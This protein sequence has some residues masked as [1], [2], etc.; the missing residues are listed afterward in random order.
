MLTAEQMAKMSPDQ[1]AAYYAA[2]SQQTAPAPVSNVKSP[3]ALGLLMKSSF[4][5]GFPNKDEKYTCYF[6]EY[7]KVADGKYT[8]LVVDTN[9]SNDDSERYS[10][11]VEKIVSIP[12]ELKKESFTIQTVGRPDKAYP[13]IEVLLD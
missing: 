5:S 9:N 8:I 11:I 6:V 3:N 13:K 2:M 10:T 7:R 1:I 12:E 4:S